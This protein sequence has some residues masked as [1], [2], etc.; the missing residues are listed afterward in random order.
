MGASKLQ[1]ELR[2]SSSGPPI[3]LV[4]PAVI[5]AMIALAA[6]SALA[7][8]TTER[9]TNGSHT[10]QPQVFDFSVKNRQKAETKQLLRD[11]R[12]A[13]SQGHIQKARRLLQQ[14]AELPWSGEPG[15]LSP[16]RLLRELDTLPK[17]DE[18]PRPNHS[19]SNIPTITELSESTAEEEV[20]TEPARKPFKQSSQK[21]TAK[22]HAA[23]VRHSDRTSLLLSRSVTSG[24]QTASSADDEE[25][26]PTADE[27]RPEMEQLNAERRREYIVLH[28]TSAAPPVPD[29]DR[30]DSTVTASVDPKI[31]QAASSS[32]QTLVNFST[33]VLSAL[34]GAVV[35]LIGVLLFLL[36]KFGPNPTIVF[37]VEMTSTGREAEPT[38]RSSPPSL[39]IAPIYAM[40]MQEEAEREQQ[41]EEAMMRKVFEDNLEL[42]EQL[43]ASRD[44]A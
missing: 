28:A 14:A 25:T 22:V 5:G 38:E 32:G 9:T 33:V 6:S 10:V 16:Q 44:A 24:Q 36:K 15:E 43:E 34:F 31:H 30:R 7:Q 12:E 4:S 2:N 21:Q 8:S 39:R 42:R 19:L 18:S 29:Q 11:A 26:S 3:F 41:Q 13:V 17:N 40:R 27:Q 20:Q 23:D 1:N 37:K 35:V